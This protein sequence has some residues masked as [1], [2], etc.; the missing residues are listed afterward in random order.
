MKKYVIIFGVA[1]AALTVALAAL[2]YAINTGGTA[3]NNTATIGA[4]F[5]ASSIFTKDQKRE[6]TA[7]EKSS[8]ALGSLG[9]SFLISMALVALVIGFLFSSKEITNNRASKH[10]VVGLCC[11]R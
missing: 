7:K 4:S 8:Y 3:L 2:A 11:C 6:P 1:Y 5:I 10:D 9:A